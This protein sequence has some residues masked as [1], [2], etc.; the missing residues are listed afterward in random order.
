MTIVRLDHCL[1]VTNKLQATRDFFVNVISLTEGS[2]PFSDSGYWLYQNDISVLHLA[3]NNQG[4]P[5]VTI[6]A[7][8]SE[9]GF[10]HLAFRATDY[11]EMYLN[12]VTHKVPFK[13][14][15]VLHLNEHQVFVQDPN[16]VTIEL[17]FPLLEVLGKQ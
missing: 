3:G 14:R 10:D 6:R 13:E 15:S 9:V 17:N 5:T 12:F 11:Q 4:D 1:I 2:R 8:R 16:G 7:Q